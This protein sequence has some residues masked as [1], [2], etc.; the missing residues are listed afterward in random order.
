MKYKTSLLSKKCCHW[1]SVSSWRDCQRN[2]ISKKKFTMQSL[3]TQR[4]NNFM[5]VTAK[6]L[7]MYL[8]AI[9]SKFLNK[10]NKIQE[11][12]SD[13]DPADAKVGHLD[14][15]SIVTKTNTSF[16]CF[17]ATLCRWIQLILIASFGTNTLWSQRWFFLQLFFIYQHICDCSVILR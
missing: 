1:K 7:F 2:P 3:E 5:I 11:S 12:S 14:I 8:G 13:S 4:I 6:I 10:R 16:S 15:F 17:Y 9:W